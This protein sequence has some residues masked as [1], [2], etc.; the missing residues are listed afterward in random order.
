VWDAALSPLDWHGPEARRLV[1]ERFARLLLR[2]DVGDSLRADQALGDEVRQLALQLA[3]EHDE[4]PKQ[5]DD[6]V[7]PVVQ[8]RGGDPAAYRLALRRQEA[9]CR[10]IPESGPYVSTLG[11]AHYRLGQFQ[12]AEAA[13]Q[14]A[15][16]LNALR[17][18]ESWP[19]DL[20]LRALLQL[21]E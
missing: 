2:S 3:E 20:A 21:Q 5:I 19:P 6:A 7:W 13:L 10:L 12:E 1:D 4:V 11:L 18:K 15:E 16:R 14:S 17:S 9:A 8:E